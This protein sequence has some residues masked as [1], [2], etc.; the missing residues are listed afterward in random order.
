MSD[1]AAHSRGAASR[2]NAERQ[3]EPGQVVRSLGLDRPPFALSGAETLESAVYS[4]FREQTIEAPWRAAEEL[5]HYLRAHY[6][7]N[8]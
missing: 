1:F 5:L 7:R 8:G 6:T 3:T 2:W 4:A